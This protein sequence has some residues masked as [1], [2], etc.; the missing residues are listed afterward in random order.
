MTAIYA[1]FSIISVSAISLIG[2]VFFFVPERNLQGWLLNIVSL[3]TGAIFG[4]VFIHML[5]E[6]QAESGMYSQA[7]L[8]VLVGILFSFVVEKFVRWRHCH[9]LPSEHCPGE[10]DPH[11]HHQHVGV[12]S[13]FG[14]TLHN[15]IDGIAIAAAFLVS[16]PVGLSTTL[17]IVLHEIPHEIG[18]FA[19]LLHSGYTKRRALLYNGLSALS[20]IAGAVLVLLVS[21]VSS[22]SGQ[23]FLPFA[24]GNL[25]YIAGSDLIPELHRQ[26]GLKESL[27]QLFFMIVGIGCMFLL[28]LWE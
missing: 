6:I 19:V 3:S 5:P 25:L 14:E 15:A 11:D 24:A 1:I 2:I 23:L 10:Q 7:M 18:N 17:A 4:D 26:T 8:T 13:L 20:A 9:V 27:W 21:Q 28:V 12:M 16:V 22:F